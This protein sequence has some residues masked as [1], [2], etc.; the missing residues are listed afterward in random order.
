MGPQSSNENLSWASI[1]AITVYPLNHLALCASFG[2]RNSV[3]PDTAFPGL[4]LVTI[5]GET[6]AGIIPQLLT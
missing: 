3:H 6:T 5:S 4:S 2:L 1:A